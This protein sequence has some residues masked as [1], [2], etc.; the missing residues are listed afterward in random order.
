MVNEGDEVDS[1]KQS[2]A[3]SQHYAVS[4]FAVGGRCKCNGHA[5]RCIPSKDEGQGTQLACDCKHNTAGR[6]CER[7]KPFHFDRP[8]GRATA[9]DANE[10]KEYLDLL[11][12]L[13]VKFSR[14]LS[15]CLVEYGDL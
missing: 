12:D 7:C 4:D 8:W 15:I 3:G 2:A 6:D 10:C 1:K 9:R 11:G 14:L 13:N 5:S